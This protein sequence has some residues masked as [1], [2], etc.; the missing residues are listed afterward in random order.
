MRSAENHHYQNHQEWEQGLWRGQSPESRDI[1]KAGCEKSRTVYGIVLHN[2]LA[3][4][5]IDELL[6]IRPIGRLPL[7]QSTQA[8]LGEDEIHDIDLLLTVRLG[9]VHKIDHKGPDCRLVTSL[10]HNSAA[11]DLR[12][13]VDRKS[14]V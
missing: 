1:L 8:N 9:E 7:L 10:H 2:L 11:K 12:E 5:G 13:Q 3:T 14:V 4:L 6:N